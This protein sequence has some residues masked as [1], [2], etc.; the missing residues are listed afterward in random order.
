M[1]PVLNLFGIVEMPLYGLC[2]LVGFL[3]LVMI[4][5]RIA[6]SY[7]IPKDDTLYACLYAGIGLG[8]GS[9][10]MYFISKL[11]NII[12]NF[13]VYVELLKKSPLD[14]IAYA[15]GGLVFYGGF[16]GAC[17]GIYIYCRQYKI[18][19]WP[20]LDIA[21]PLIPFVHAFGR[22]GCFFAGCCYGIEYRGI[23]S[24]QYPENELSPQLADVPRFPVQLLE[25]LLNFIFCGILFY[26]QKKRKVKT[27]QLM[28]F[29]LL[30]YTVARF[31]L[32][33]LRGDVNRGG[34]NG[35]STSQIVSII[36][37]PIGILLASGKWLPK[38]IEKKNARN[39]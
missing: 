21:A 15:F 37:L 36:L 13:D 4:A 38:Y 32:E 16:L 22:I 26:I 28:G 2:F 25:A 24:I 14:G 31:F 7:G 35:V 9:K 29:Y 18:P 5:R 1:Y 8:I 17:L 6:P 20:F 10:V 19:F 12:L 30:Y 23:F 33:M 39:V 11:P 3:F 34:I 27:G